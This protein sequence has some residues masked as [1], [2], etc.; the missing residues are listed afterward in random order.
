MDITYVHK[1]KV[2]YKRTREPSFGTRMFVGEDDQVDAALAEVTFEA[3]SQSRLLVAAWL[4]L[5][6]RLPREIED[7][8]AIAMQE[9]QR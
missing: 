8:L 1:I 4:E 6:D 5:I 9:R 3:T 7:A 2:E